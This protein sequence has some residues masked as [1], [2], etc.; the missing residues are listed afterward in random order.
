MFL[1]LMHQQGAGA[2]AG[3]APEEAPGGE[4]GTGPGE[5]GSV[6]GAEPAPDDGASALENKK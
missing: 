6:S 5:H 3:V 2:F 4:G 1:H